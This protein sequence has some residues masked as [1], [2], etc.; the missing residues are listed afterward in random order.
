MKTKFVHSNSSAS[1]ASFS[2]FSNPN[3]SQARINPTENGT[4]EYY[5][6]VKIEYNHKDLDYAGPSLAERVFR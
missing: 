4:D 1:L 6:G 5:E 2:G 3:N